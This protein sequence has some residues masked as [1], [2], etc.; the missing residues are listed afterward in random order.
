MNLLTDE[1]IPV[2]PQKPGAARHISLKALLCGN[3]RWELALPRDDMELAAL[4]LL[5]CLVQVMLPPADER[6]WRERIVKPLD[7]DTLNRATN[8]YRDWFQLDHPDYPFMQVR[9]VKAKVDTAMDKLLAGLD[10]STNSRFVNEPDMAS[11]L[12][13]GCVAIA[14]YNQANNAPSYGGGFKFGLRGSCPVTTFSQGQDLR[15]TIS[16]QHTFN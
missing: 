11:G 14:L 15:T 16:A 5:I 2:R 3:E 10:S 1:W 6:Q 12:C 13:F 8:P 7:L 4:Q 9:G